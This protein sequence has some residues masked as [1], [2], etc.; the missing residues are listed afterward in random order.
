MRFFTT[1][2][3]ATG[4]G[5]KCLTYAPAGYGKTMLCATAPA[6][7]LLSAESGL[8]S[9]RRPNIER[10]FGPGR[11]DICYDI[12]GAEIKSMDDLNEA[13][14]WLK[15]SA[16]S[17]YF[18]TVEIDS[19]TEIA[20]VLL[21]KERKI[22]KDPRQAYG[23][24]I[25]KMMQLLRDFRD[26]PGKHVYMSAKMEPFRDEA[27]GS[28]KYGPSMPGTKLGVQLPYLFD[29]V[30]RM[31]TGVDQQG[32]PFRFLQTQPD[33]QYEAKDRS[34][35]LAPIEYPHLYSVFNKIAG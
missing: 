6:P 14:L 5:V 8:L 32:Q 33:A 30:F 1:Q 16:E 15:G 11:Q 9:L 22:N 7:F 24:L 26:L 25:T 13:Y 20:E 18:L 3:A 17:R 31:G 34:G 10:V 29:E 35:A 28:T 4:S 23:E 21:A 12:P 27:T 19:I 2:Q